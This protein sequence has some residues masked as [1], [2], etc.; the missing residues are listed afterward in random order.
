MRL[1]RLF[2]LLATLASLPGYG[3]AATGHGGGCTDAV[4]GGTPVTAHVMDHAM[5]MDTQHDCC[6]GA[7]DPK[8]A[9]SPHEGCPACVAGHAC[10]STQC[11]QPPGEFVLRLLPLHAGVSDEPSPHASLCGPDGLLR[12]PTLS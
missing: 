3:L 1:F 12:P 4:A 7:A 2:I 8:P 11:A 10:K 5:D 9:S 6:P